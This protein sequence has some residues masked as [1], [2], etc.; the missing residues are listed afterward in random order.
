M[1]SCYT[2]EPMPS[3]QALFDNFKD[4]VGEDQQY[5]LSEQLKK[6]TNRLKS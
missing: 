1:I 2:F 4:F 5:L 3:I 6:P